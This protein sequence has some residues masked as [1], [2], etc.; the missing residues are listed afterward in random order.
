VCK[1]RFGIK[2]SKSS[3]D[4]EH[5]KSQAKAPDIKIINTRDKFL[6]NSFLSTSWTRWENLSLRIEKMIDKNSND[7]LMSEANLW[8]AKPLLRF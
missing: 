5:S 6:T 4:T 2:A 3:A 1:H 8:S 7:L